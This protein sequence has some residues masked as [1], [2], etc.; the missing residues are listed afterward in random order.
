ML[1]L[2]FL[3]VGLLCAIVGRILLA[4]AAFDI[5]VWWGVGV[6][7]PFGPLLFRLNYPVAGE[8]SR[9]FRL[10]TIPCLFLYLLLGPR[11]TNT[12][13]F[14]HKTK[15]VQPLHSLPPQYAIQVSAKAAKGAPSS[16]GPTVETMP[17]LEER[18]AVNVRE[19]VRLN[20][21]KEALRLRKRDLLRSDVAGN[22]LYNVD[23]AQYNAAFEKANAERSALWPAAK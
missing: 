10:A 7:L 15:E 12:D 11:V 9:M 5:S 18:R 23:L 2:F 19:F 4:S 20:A 17:S 14:R 21:W 8:Q 22:E 6:F 1:G 13:Y 3:F 16:G